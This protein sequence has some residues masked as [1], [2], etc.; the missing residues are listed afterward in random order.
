M[1]SLTSLLSH[2]GWNM[3]A[4]SPFNLHKSLTVRSRWRIIKALARLVLSISQQNLVLLIG[5]YMLDAISNKSAFWSWSSVCLRSL[6]AIRLL[7]WNDEPVCKGGRNNAALA[8]PISNWSSLE[9]LMRH[10]L[11]WSFMIRLRSVATRHLSV[12]I[13]WAYQ[14]ADARHDLIFETRHI[15]ILFRCMSSHKSLFSRHF[16]LI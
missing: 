15:N 3:T 6:H 1:Q 11:V 9:L 2:L 14:I 7:L 5:N 12:S 10:N 13:V 4:V 16:K 8:V